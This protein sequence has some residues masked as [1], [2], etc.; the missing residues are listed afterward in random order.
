MALKT[1]PITLPFS[2]HTTN[3]KKLWE[4]SVEKRV[5]TLWEREKAKRGEHL[6][7]GTTLLVDFIGPASVSVTSSEYKYFLAQSL[8]STLRSEMKL[9]ALAVTGLASYQDS[10]LLGKRSQTVQTEAGV[11]ELVPAGGVTS[12]KIRSDGNVDFLQQLLQELEEETGLAGNAVQD[13]KPFALVEDET[14]G[15]LDIG[16]EI[17]L[18]SLD[19]LLTS[20]EEYEK[21]HLVPRNKLSS[22]SLENSMA[23]VSKKFLEKIYGHI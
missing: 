2:V 22:F 23:P 19:S 18:K 15:T 13:L 9:R 14:L 20:S 6:F 16:I 21:I 11:W 17:S 1:Y 3:Q 12:D 10:I 5:D 7:N 4:S 8:D